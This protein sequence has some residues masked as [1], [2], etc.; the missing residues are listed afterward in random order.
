MLKMALDSLPELLELN[1]QQKAVL[2]NPHNYRFL[3]GTQPNEISLD[4]FLQHLKEHKGLIYGVFFN[5]NSANIC[6][7]DS[8]ENQRKDGKYSCLSY[9]TFP[10]DSSM[11][12]IERE[13]ER[14]SS[15][16]RVFEFN[17]IPFIYE[18]N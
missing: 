15:T 11:R 12:G 3:L 4:L 9:H 5:P 1:Q 8:K 10:F 6:F 13:I 18:R 14:Y 16:S 2:E 7:L 17:P